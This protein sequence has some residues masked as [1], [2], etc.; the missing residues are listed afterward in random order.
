MAPGEEEATR[1]WGMER[2]QPTALS[3]VT[4][5]DSCCSD[6]SSCHSLMLILCSSAP[7]FC[8]TV[9]SLPQ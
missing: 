3:H 6:V 5:R 1:W 7:L 9:V 4:E 2:I 8:A